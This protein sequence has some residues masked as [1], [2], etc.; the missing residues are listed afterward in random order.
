MCPYI[1]FDEYDTT[2]VGTE[3]RRLSMHL[4]I[5]F[6][7]RATVRFGVMHFPS[8]LHAAHAFVR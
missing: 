2:V 1:R 4:R 3:Q 8:F 7:A 5:F 6:V